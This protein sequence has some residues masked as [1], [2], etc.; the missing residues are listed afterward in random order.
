MTFGEDKKNDRLRTEYFGGGGWITAFSSHS[1]HWRAM[2]FRIWGVTVV[3]EKR[4]S[5]GRNRH[6]QEVSHHCIKQ[7]R[8]IRPAGGGRRL[9]VRPFPEDFVHQARIRPG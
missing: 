5:P 9:E 8:R 4:T 2:E 1:C 6:S 3:L 7:L